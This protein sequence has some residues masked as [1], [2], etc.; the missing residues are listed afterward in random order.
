MR[1]DRFGAG[2]A[3]NDRAPPSIGIAAGFSTRRTCVVREA[4]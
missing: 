2:F 3:K 4:V 1:L